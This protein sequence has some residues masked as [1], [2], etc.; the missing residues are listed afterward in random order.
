M[1]GYIGSLFTKCCD[2]R[3]DKALMSLRVTIR[4]FEQYRYALLLH[5][6]KYLSKHLLIEK[7][8][9]HKILFIS[10]YN[11]SYYSLLGGVGTL[12]LGST[13]PFDSIQFVLGLFTT[14]L[15]ECPIVKPLQIIRNQTRI[16][17]G[18]KIVRIIS[19]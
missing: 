5:L 11:C 14:F 7:K 3:H 17:S 13:H 15:S 6:Q 4:N 9:S 2:E 1:F 8:N 10:T 18:P 12:S 19:P 16:H